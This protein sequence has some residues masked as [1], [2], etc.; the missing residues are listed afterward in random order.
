MSDIQKMQDDILKTLGLPKDA[1][2]EDIMAAMQ[3][4]GA[5]IGAQKALEDILS[6]KGKEEAAP[7]E[8]PGPDG[9]EM[10]A[11]DD[12][13]KE[14]DKVE[15]GA[16]KVAASATEVEAGEAPAAPVVNAAEG[17]DASLAA[18]KQI[19]DALIQA[20]GLDAAGAVAFIQDN[21]D[22]IAALAGKQPESGAPSDAP[23]AEGA[24]AQMASKPADDAKMS[25]AA[26]RIAALAKENAELKSKEAER[27][28]LAAMAKAEAMVT[29]AIVAGK[30]L[31]TEKASLIK[32]ALGDPATFEKWTAEK[33][34]AVPV[35]EHS[36]PPAPDTQR[37]MTTLSD[38][39]RKAYNQHLRAGTAHAKALEL[40]TNP[41]AAKALRLAFAKH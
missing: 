19:L 8:P 1:G 38:V 4:I 27:T 10:S 13:A 6:G 32:F 33:A 35:T 39:E 15:A 29:A 17:D 3:A 21:L 14:K 26:G 2:P 24:P 41:E 25:A 5:A 23:A 18:G 22:A 37:S 16:E 40:A 11:E 20:T 30:F 12:K 28:K 34:N 31:D 9:A 7:S 36:A